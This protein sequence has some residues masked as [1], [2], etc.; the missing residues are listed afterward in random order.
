M[1]SLVVLILALVFLFNPCPASAQ[2]SA[3]QGK[4]IVEEMLVAVS[5]VN[6]LKFKLRRI[7]RIESKLLKSEADMKYSKSLKAAYSYMLNPT[8]GLELLYVDGKNGN[9]A[10]VNPNSFPYITLNLDP[11]GGAMRKDNHHTIHEV[12]FGYISDI[13]S[14][15]TR[16]PGNEYDKYFS[17]QGEIL[18]DNRPCYKVVIDYSSAFKYIPYTV[19]PGETLTSIGYEHFVNDYLILEKNPDLDDYYDVKPGQ[20][21]QMPNAY[22]AKTV[23]YI[24]KA[25][26]MPILQAMYD[27]KGLYEQ[28]EFLNLQVN[29]KIPEEEFT[30]DYKDYNF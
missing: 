25:N 8:K 30:K 4:K 11:Y 9:N 1:K 15:M 13:I 23:L 5:K 6:T 3:E 7:E 2:S 28:Y 20:V 16:K 29:P 12:G 24:D 27:E 19:K 21:I 14:Y 18:F 10:C 22:A 26:Y 17:Y